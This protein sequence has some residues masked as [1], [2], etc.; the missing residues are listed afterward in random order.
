ME[1]AP[2]RERLIAVDR[3]AGDIEMALCRIRNEGSKDDR[4][5]EEIRLSFS[6]E[7]HEKA[8]LAKR[9][10]DLRPLRIRV[11]DGAYPLCGAVNGFLG[12]EYDPCYQGY[13]GGF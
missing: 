12:I 6:L 7:V 3:R 9:S 8:A 4:H 1:S 5:G 2:S 11:I 13:L 10:G